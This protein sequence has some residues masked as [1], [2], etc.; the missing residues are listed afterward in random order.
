[1]KPITLS[2]SLLLTIGCTMPAADAQTGTFIDR[3]AATELRVVSY[4]VNWDSIFPDGDPNNHNWRDFDKS[5]DFERIIAALDPDVMC[6]QEINSSRNAQDVADIFDAVLPLGGGQGWHAAIGYSNVIV[7]RY[8]LSMV[9]TTTTPQGQRDQCMA[10]VDLPDAEFD[11]DVYVIN[12]HFKCCGGSSSNDKRQKQADSLVNWMRDAR[13]PGEAIDLPADTPIILLGDLNI[14]DGLV[15]PLNTV[16]SGN[17]SDEGAYGADSPPD[18]DGTVAGDV[19]PLHNVA[20]PDDYTWRDDGSPYAP[21]RL[22]YLTLSDSILTIV[23]SFVLDTTAMSGAE[24]A[25]TGLQQ[26]DVVLDPPGRFDH[27]PLV[28]DLQFPQAAITPDGDLSLDGLVNGEDV[29]F[30][31]VEYL[32]GAAGDPTRIAH[33]DYSANGLVDDADLSGF[34]A[35]LLGS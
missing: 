21:G 15:G 34:V 12:E 31:V 28:A 13:S 29:E 6:L 8:P 17:I 10:L 9:E 5:Q 2:L 11:R 19:Q 3:P 30:F 32:A 18:W 33:G 7:S 26:F 4:N 22:D 23:Q 16:L 25:A 14:V 35:D 27:L 1:M 20:G 24:L